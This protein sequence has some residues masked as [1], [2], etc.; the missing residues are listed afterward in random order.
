MVE[1]IE[2]TLTQ[3][4]YEAMLDDPNY[5]YTAGD[6]TAFTKITIV[7]DTSGQVFTERLIT[8]RLKSDGTKY[9][10][11][12]RSTSFGSNSYGSTAEESAA[13]WAKM[14]SGN[15]DLAAEGY[16]EKANHYVNIFTS[17]GQSVERAT[18]AANRLT[19][20]STKAISDITGLDFKKA[21][22]L[23]GGY[24]IEQGRNLD[25]IVE[26]S[27][28]GGKL[29]SSAFLNNMRTANAQVINRGI[30]LDPISTERDAQGNPVDPNAIINAQGQIVDG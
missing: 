13:T 16:Q 19:Y 30:R 27:K 22:A 21:V 26:A 1:I 24:V 25:A 15:P 9:E 6:D 28:V 23:K 2:K 12:G 7:N 17:R 8:P 18:D 10:S 4:Q 29:S 20:S 14:N 11:R 3:S 5:R